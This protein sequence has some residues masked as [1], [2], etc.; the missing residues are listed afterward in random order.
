MRKIDDA[1]DAKDQRQPRRHQEQRGGVGEAAEELK[2]KSAHL[3]I[4]LDQHF[5]RNQQLVM[6]RPHM[7]ER[8]PAFSLQDLVYTLARA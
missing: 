4:G 5:R 8:K 2:S 1:R 3:L 7:F 6:Q